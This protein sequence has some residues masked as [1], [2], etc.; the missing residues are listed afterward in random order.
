MKLSNFMFVGFL[1]IYSFAYCDIVSDLQAKKNNNQETGI[2]YD[3]VVPGEYDGKKPVKY[4]ITE[5]EGN[6]LFESSNFQDKMYLLAD[7]K[8]FQIPSSAELDPMAPT[9]VVLLGEDVK[10]I[11]DEYDKKFQIPD[12]TNAEVI[13]SAKVNGYQCKILQKI[14]SDKEMKNKNGS[15]FKSQSLLKMYVTEKFGYP[16]RIENI[17]KTQDI[18]GTEIESE[19]KN[20]IDFV[21]FRTNIASKFIT[22]PVNAMIINAVNPVLFDKN[23]N[24]SHQ[25]QI[26]KENNEYRN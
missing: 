21:K 26:L 8:L 12:Y 18:K 16:T 5:K 14:V 9:T 22:I 24:K 10:A 25:Q 6:K 4:S 23:S 20:T 11:I 7:G 17:F 19:V 13:G 2:Y 3:V 15:K 1:L